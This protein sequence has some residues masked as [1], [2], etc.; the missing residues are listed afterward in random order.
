MFLNIEGQR[1]LILF[2]VFNAQNTN[3]TKLV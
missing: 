1:S 3:K 2:E